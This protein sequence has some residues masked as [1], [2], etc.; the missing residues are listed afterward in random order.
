MVQVGA[1]V[2]GMETQGLNLDANQK[3]FPILPG[4][5][6]ELGAVVDTRPCATHSLQPSDDDNIKSHIAGRSLKLSGP[7]SLSLL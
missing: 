6:W 3:P 2:S 4:W 1:P 7:E 5:S